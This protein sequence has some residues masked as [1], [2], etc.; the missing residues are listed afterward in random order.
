MSKLTTDEKFFFDH[1]GYSYGKGETKRQGRERGARALAQA[2]AKA[3]QGGFSFVW[4]IDPDTDS[5]DWSD[6][7]PAWRVWQ[8]CMLNPEGRIVDSL[9]GIDFGRDGEPWG[10][11]YKRIVEAELAL[12]G[13]DNEPQAHYAK[14]QIDAARRALVRAKGN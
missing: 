11:P 10:D 5:S 13:L 3:R 6:D 12:S 9:H 8:C 14:D 2:E 4:Q 1:A 7:E